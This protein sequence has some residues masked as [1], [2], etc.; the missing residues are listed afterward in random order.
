MESI[1]SPGQ[2]VMTDE[3]DVSSGDVNPRLLFDLMNIRNQ[4]LNTQKVKFRIS[5]THA[6]IISKIEDDGMMVY[7]KSRLEAGLVSLGLV[8]LAKKNNICTTKIA[9]LEEGCEGL[10]VEKN[11]KRLEKLVYPLNITHHITQEVLKDCVAKYGDNVYGNIILRK[12]G[13]PEIKAGS[14]VKLNTETLKTFRNITREKF[15]EHRAGRLKKGT[16]ID[17]EITI[18]QVLIM[19]AKKY[20]FGLNRDGVLGDT[21]RLSL[22]LGL[23]LLSEWVL[24]NQYP[25]DEYHLSRIYHKINNFFNDIGLQRFSLRTKREKW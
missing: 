16:N 13:C 20:R 22:I 6:L 24:K 19:I 10:S 3:M 2:G 5:S 18:P 8:Y 17:V 21:Y 4:E 23:R 9:L 7:K 14:I 1:I 12:L 15:S 11:T 25:K